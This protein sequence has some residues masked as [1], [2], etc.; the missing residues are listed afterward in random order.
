[1]VLHLRVSM[2][3]APPSAARLCQPGAHGTAANA[4]GTAKVTHS[5]GAAPATGSG[6]QLMLSGI[7]NG[8]T[9]NTP[10]F[11]LIETFS[12]TACTTAVDSSTV[13]FSWTD[14]TEVNATI[15]PAMTFTVDP[16][17]GGSCN[18]ADHYWCRYNPSSGL[19][20]H[21]KQNVTRHRWTTPFRR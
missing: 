2:Q 10:V 12:D 18:G 13:N 21:G 7:T 8:S 15:D 20:R 6:V 5:S 17:N 4:G 3:P 11:A 19:A 16:I 1:M 9:A 14:N